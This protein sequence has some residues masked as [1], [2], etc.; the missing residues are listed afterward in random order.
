MADLWLTAEMLS[1]PDDTSTCFPALKSGVTWGLLMGALAGGLGV[2][3]PLFHSVS[4]LSLGLHLQWWGAVALTP[5]SYPAITMLLQGVPDTR[6]PP[7]PRCVCIAPLPSLGLRS[8]LP[9]G[10]V[11]SSL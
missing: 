7:L 10:S 5:C 8:R 4:L 6:K 9:R 2:E 3:A 11:L 1:G